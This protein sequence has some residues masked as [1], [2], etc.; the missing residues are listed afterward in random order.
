MTAA[1]VLAVAGLA[2]VV[3]LG[4]ACPELFQ[5]DSSARSVAGLAA[6]A[7]AYLTLAASSPLIG[8]WIADATGFK[9]GG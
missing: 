9:I 6:A 4:L 7:I 3:F 2:V 8:L 5:K 1:L